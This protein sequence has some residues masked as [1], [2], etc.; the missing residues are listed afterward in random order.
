MRNVFLV[1]ALI[2]GAS[3]GISR[4]D[5]ENEIL[6]EDNNGNRRQEMIE[7]N[8][9][10]KVRVEGDGEIE[11]RFDVRCEECELFVRELDSMLRNPQYVNALKVF[12]KEYACNAMPQTLKEYCESTIDDIQIVL[13]YLEPMMRDAKQACLDVGMCQGSGLRMMKFGVKLFKAYLE[14]MRRGFRSNDL[15]CDECKFAIGE[16]HSIIQSKDFQGEFRQSV[17]Q[18]CD[19]CPSKDKC[20]SFIDD[21]LP[22]F[23]QELE[24]LTADSQGLCSELG[25]CTG[26]MHVMSMKLH[27]A[28]DHVTKVIT[29]DGTTPNNRLKQFYFTLRRLHGKK[30]AGLG[31]LTCQFAVN[32]LKKL[33]MDNKPLLNNTVQGVENM[34]CNRLPGDLK[35]Q[36]IDFLNLYGS[37]ALIML[38]QE[39]VDPEKICTGVQAC[40]AT[41]LRIIEQNANERGLLECEA[42]TGIVEY[43]KYELESKEFQDSIVTALKQLCQSLFHGQSTEQQLLACISGTESYSPYILQMYGEIINFYRRQICQDIGMCEGSD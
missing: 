2:L 31:C 40:D 25:L 29:L 24:S 9:V 22:T 33:I 41:D 10:P 18:L 17:E 26:G 42:C 14:K 30:G 37:A 11:I 36:C 1:C 3:A 43:I 8:R 21:F 27:K 6:I 38:V 23:F 20:K 35:D 5:S 15:A 19:Y 32:S 39:E 13:D 4:Q 7:S 28:Y 16:L 12:L 34:I